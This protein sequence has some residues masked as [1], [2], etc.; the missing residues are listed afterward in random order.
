MRA[1]FLAALAVALLAPCARAQD[2]EATPD[3]TAF[4]LFRLET[5][6]RA[7]ALAG[8]GDALA[9][10]GDLSVVWH[11]PALLTDAMH[12][13]LSVGYLNHY[14]D[15]SAGSAS[16]ARTLP[17]VGTVAAGVRFLSYGEFERADENGAT[18]G[19]TFGAGTT[20]LSLV[21]ARP[22]VE[23]ALPGGGTLRGG[24]ALHAAFSSV[25][26]ARAQALAADLGLVYEMAAS[27]FAVGAALRGLGTVTQSLGATTDRLPMDLRLTV[28]KRLR[29]IP[30]TLSASGYDLQSVGGA[31]GSALDEAL[32]HVA[33]GGELRLGQALDARFG[34][35]FRRD[36]DLGTGSRLNL[37]GLS[38]GFGLDLRRVAFDYAFQGWGDF[39]ALH[40]LAVRTRI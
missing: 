31:G 36:D 19:S 15:V 2:D 34:Y 3:G 8:T 7:A 4:D 20:A 12:R 5:S 32:R 29:Y 10:A 28:A 23:G 30:L 26:D 39:G 40:Q 27:G 16:Y 38:A 22:L 35:N 18:D 37:A 17:R 25:D 14:R 24:V 9:D 6:T 11:N 13:G 21:V 33:L 1:L